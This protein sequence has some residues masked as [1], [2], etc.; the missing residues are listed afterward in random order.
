MKSGTKIFSFTVLDMWQP[1]NATVNGVNS[2]YVTIN[3]M[4]GYSEESNGNKYL[5]L[6]CTGESKNFI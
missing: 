6:V 1:K 5:T 2:L 3:K 4:N